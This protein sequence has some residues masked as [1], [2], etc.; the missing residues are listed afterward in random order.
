MHYEKLLVATGA[1]PRLP[2]IDNNRAKGVV[3][4]R[5]FDDI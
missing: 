5:T 1:S 3:T 2:P 4:V